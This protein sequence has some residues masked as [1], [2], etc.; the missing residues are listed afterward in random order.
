[1]EKLTELAKKRSL[2]DD[3]LVEMEELSQIIKQVT[4]RSLLIYFYA[5][6][7]IHCFMCLF[8]A[9]S[10]IFRILLASTNR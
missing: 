10:I 5:S 9:P 3:R 2:F 6:F 7:F 4:Y 8:E 1:M